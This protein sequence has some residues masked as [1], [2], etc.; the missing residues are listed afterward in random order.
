MRL[1]LPQG[2]TRL[3]KL[4]GGLPLRGAPHA[5]P[6]GDSRS[7]RGRL[8]SSG[9]ARAPDGCGILL[10]PGFFSACCALAQLRRRFEAHR[11]VFAPGSGWWL[12]GLAGPCS[13]GHRPLAA[14]RGP[15]GP[16]A[17]P[18]ASASGGLHVDG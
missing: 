10:E 1:P 9:R 16:G 5:C 2:V 14:L 4:N 3:V 7:A 11:P 13:G 12:G 6:A 8:P 18:W 15:R 17:G